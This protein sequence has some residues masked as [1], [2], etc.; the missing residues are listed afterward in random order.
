MSDFVLTEDNY[1][2]SEADKHFM[3]VHQYL[4]FSGHMGV[5]GC[6][7]RA[8]AK[9]NG[10]WKEETTDAMLV[11]SYVDSYFEGTLKQFLKEHP[12]FE[13]EDFKEW[14][15]SSSKGKFYHMLKH[16]FA[17]GWY[18]TNPFKIIDRSKIKPT[19]K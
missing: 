8:L 19:K 10:E 16:R 13:T 5:V 4:D 11:G 18:E 12:E 1:Y 17:R 14:I 2:S 9:L 6:E 3:S 7:E 15:S